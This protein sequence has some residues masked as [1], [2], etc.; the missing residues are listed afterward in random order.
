ME[1]KAEPT[2][3]D[4]KLFLVF[5]V[6]FAAMTVFEF[7][8][9]F[10]YPFP[11]DWRSNLITSLF[12]S[13]LA[14]IIAYFPLNSNYVKNLQL[15]S[16]MERRRSVETELRE[17]ESHLASIIRV[18]PVGIGVV[19]DRTIRTVNDQLCHI[20]GY[21]AEELIGKPARSLY[22]AQD[23]YDYV[24]RENYC[25]DRTERIRGGRDPVAEE[26]RDDY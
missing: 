9:Q 2:P 10:L 1:S 17:S 12:T 13:G 23:D 4:Q 26:R 21:A 24:G 6:T 11:P 8:G 20:T 22:P 7:A 18:A 19:S 14:V 16:E 5:I 3:V 15:F 25:P